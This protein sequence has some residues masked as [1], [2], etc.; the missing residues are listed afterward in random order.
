MKTIKT[1]LINKFETLSLIIASIIMSAFLLVFRIKLNKSF[2]FLFLIW[3]LILA[4]IPYIITMYLST[5]K[6]SKAKLGF[7]FCIWLLFL[8]NSPYIITD[9]L[10]IRIS[11]SSFL[12]LDILMILSFALSGVFLFFL[13]LNQM[14]QLLSIYFKKIPV[15]FFISS[16]I[17]LSAFGVYLGRYLR[18]NSWE[19]LSNPQHLSID[20]LNM[21]LHPITNKGIWLFTFGFGIFLFIGFKM[22]NKIKKENIDLR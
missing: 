19:V 21:F 3:N 16:I 6:L 9:L 22:F 10:H 12:W 7:W 18:Y 8:P 17:F 20:I 1:L 2:S 13:S 11:E 14:K 15:D 5:S 4:I